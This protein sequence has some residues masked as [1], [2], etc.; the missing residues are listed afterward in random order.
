VRYEEED[1]D[2]ESELALSE[3]QQ[4]KHASR[5]L[6]PHHPR[7][8][9]LQLFYR[10]LT[11]LFLAAA[12][13]NT[14]NYKTESASIGFCDTGSTTNSALESLRS[15]RAASESCNR[16]N[17]T[18]LYLPS[19]RSEGSQE[20]ET[21]SCPLPPLIPVPQP[22][23][24]TPCPDHA[25]CT[26]FSVLCDNGYLLRPYTLLGFMP[27]PPSSFNMTL[28]SSL[29][30]SE[31]AWTALS[32]ALDGL[33]GLGSI[34]LPPRC[35]LDPKR[36]RNIGALGKAME[37]IL[38][39]ERGRRLC[40][41]GRDLDK[42][43]EDSQGGEAR[44]WG[45]EIEELREMMKRKT[46]V[47]VSIPLLPSHFLSGLWFSGVRSMV[48]IVLG[49]LIAFCGLFFPLSPGSS[50]LLTIHSMKQFK[51]SCSGVG[52]LSVLIKSTIH[53]AAH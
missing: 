22:D 9:A 15:Y 45:V 23:S 32:N 37:S 24:C 42:E 25:T 11:V 3:M 10:V 38:S 16:E 44:K 18:T 36:Q 1:E 26:Q 4:E 47:C 6:I 8:G 43:L 27:P 29:G 19:L 48:T 46:S 5:A 34:A 50:L 13:Y 40:V 31:M 20:A 14:Y 30:P 21:E 35:V 52:L 2:E 33:P 7:S 39:Q 12:G 17:R 28:S 41:G 49:V 53:C 51:S